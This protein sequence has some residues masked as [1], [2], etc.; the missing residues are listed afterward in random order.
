MT[1]FKVPSHI[2]NSY[3]W[4]GIKF[5]KVFITQL[6][7]YIISNFKVLY[8][9]FRGYILRKEVNSFPQIFVISSS[10]PIRLQFSRR[11]LQQLN[12]GSGCFGKPKRRKFI[13]RDSAAILD[14]RGGHFDSDSSLS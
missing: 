11:S 10:L 5:L 8:Q 13:L 12:R 9:C 14:L 1:K 2:W 4:R 3:F 7:T 6:N